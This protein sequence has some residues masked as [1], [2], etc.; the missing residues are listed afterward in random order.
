MRREDLYF[1]VSLI[2][3]TAVVVAVI[4]SFLAR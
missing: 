2:W 3:L 4:F 1:T